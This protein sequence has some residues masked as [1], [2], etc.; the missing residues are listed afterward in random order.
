MLKTKVVWVHLHLAVFVCCY[1]FLEEIPVSHT[2]QYTVSLFASN[3]TFTCSFSFTQ[4][5]ST[6]IGFFVAHVDRVLLYWQNNMVLTTKKSTILIM[7][8]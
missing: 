8:E 3:V 4:T 7:C 5:V 6:I 2:I 1:L